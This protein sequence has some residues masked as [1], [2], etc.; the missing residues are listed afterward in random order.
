MVYMK[1]LQMV[2]DHVHVIQ[3]VPILFN[4]ISIQD[5]VPVEKV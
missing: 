3:V 4:V 5:N 2:V 1:I